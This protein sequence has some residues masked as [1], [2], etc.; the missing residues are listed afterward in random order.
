MIE[1][2]KKGYEQGIEPPTERNVVSVSATLTISGSSWSVT[3]QE[4]KSVGWAIDAG[5]AGELAV[6]RFGKTL[7]KLADS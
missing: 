2:T 7:K 3:H 5:D 4:V 6:R 1:I